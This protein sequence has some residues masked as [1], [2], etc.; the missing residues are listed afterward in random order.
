MLVQH[1]E[2]G[3]GRML[4][5]SVILKGRKANTCPGRHHMGVSQMLYWHRTIVTAVSIPQL[6]PSST[7]AT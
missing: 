2:V 1:S 3:L 6:S 7:T 5:T 4:R